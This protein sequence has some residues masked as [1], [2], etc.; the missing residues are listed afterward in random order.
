MSVTD[1][2]LMASAD[3]SVGR[4]FWL[5]CNSPQQKTTPTQES[6]EVDMSF[7]YQSRGQYIPKNRHVT[8]PMKE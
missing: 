7:L 1:N 3:M 6:E 4:Q 2:F 8:I 5:S